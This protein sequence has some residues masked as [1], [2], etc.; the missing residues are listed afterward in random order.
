MMAQT[1]QPVKKALGGKMREDDAQAALYDPLKKAFA[2]ACAQGA[3][4]RNGLKQAWRM[5]ADFVREGKLVAGWNAAAG[6]ADEDY[7]TVRARDIARRYDKLIV[8][9]R[10][11]AF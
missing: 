10:G 7:K 3:P 11:A 6:S 5:C 2:K 8:A 1:L 9:R 4:D